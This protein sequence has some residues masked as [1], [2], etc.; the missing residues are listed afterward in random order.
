MV[1]HGPMTVPTNS[2]F[3]WGGGTGPYIMPRMNYPPRY[4]LIP[5]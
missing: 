2:T 1:T 4:L 5:G 3:V